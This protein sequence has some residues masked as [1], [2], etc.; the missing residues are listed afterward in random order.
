M[1]FDKASAADITGRGATPLVGG[2]ESRDK[3]TNLKLVLVRA[4][5]ITQGAKNQYGDAGL[6]PLEIAKQQV[7][8]HRQARALKR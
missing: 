7:K 2:S 5:H 1:P 8:L 6:N 3:F 4:L